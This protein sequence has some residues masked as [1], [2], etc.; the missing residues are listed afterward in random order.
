MPVFVSL[1]AMHDNTEINGFLAMITDISERKKI[2][3]M[4]SEFISM[5]SHELRT[6]LTSIRGSLGLI[7]GG[8]AGELPPKAK[9]LVD[10]AGK[11]SERLVR[12]IN[13]ILD[14]EKIEAGKMAFDIKPLPLSDLITQTL[15]AN[16]GY[17][18]QFKVSLK[19]IN[20]APA[21]MVEADKDRLEQV[22]T[23]LISNA[24]KFSPEGGEVS[25]TLEKTPLWV[26]VTIAD[27]GPG[28]PEEFRQR[29]FQKFA[30][31]DSSDS[32][33]K[34]GTGLGL[35]IT[36]AI[37]ERLR[38]HIGFHSEVGQGTAFFFRLPEWQTP[39]LTEIEENSDTDAEVLI[40]EDDPD[41]AMLLRLYLKE[42]GIAADVAGDVKTA[43]EKLEANT[44]RAMTLDLNLP[45][46]N[47]LSFLHQLRS[48][49]KYAHL[50]IIV[51][52]ANAKDGQQ[53]VAGEVLDV[54]DWL[55]KP[56]DNTRLTRVIKDALKHRTYQEG[57]KAHILHVE[58]N[59]DIRHVVAELLGDNIELGSAAN[60]QSARAYLK[61]HKVDLVLLDIGLPDG[62]GL[63][64]LPELREHTR[65]PVSVV[66]FSA[67]QVPEDV[68]RQVSAALI[69]S[70]TAN[71][72]LREAV[73]N[74]LSEH[75]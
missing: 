68:S 18:E 39:Q 64:L 73:L 51:V 71:E 12:L 31:A 4:K 48:T 32:R 25:I 52:S 63:E 42:A 47:G 67:Q 24:C 65:S 5:V 1:T 16:Q 40:C 23:N 20:H 13:D 70:H 49:P 53:A 6:P 35:S 33:Q 22:L 34:G 46:E 57:E 36:K 11:N 66:I 26:S 45:D 60:L 59:E 29:I 62:S 43:R 3:R 28:I 54:I 21:V 72:T 61:V 15:S 56:I 10:I 14:V 44:Y 37:I 38:G 75:L 30:Q 17:A 8:A 55:P 41:V 27:Q 19:F 2:D 50:P 74:A 7:S 69:K 9:Q 58:D